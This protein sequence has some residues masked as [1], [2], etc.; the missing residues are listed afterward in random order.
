MTKL[1]KEAQIKLLRKMWIT[2]TQYKVLLALCFL[3]S[4]PALLFAYI[5]ESAI[6]VV[7]AIVLMGLGISLLFTSPHIQN[8]IGG[9]YTT[10]KKEAQVDMY[11]NSSLDKNSYCATIYTPKTTWE[12]EFAPL[13]W[14]PNIK[15]KEYEAHYIS[16]V[17]WPVLL[18][19]EDG[20]L[21]PHL[22]PKKV[23]DERLDFKKSRPTNSQELAQLEKQKRKELE[24][25]SKYTMSPTLSAHKKAKMPAPD[26]KVYT[27][28]K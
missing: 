7:L 21:Y 1:N 9:T 3:V 22:N 19:C 10:H 16:G 15:N 4:P 12:M 24:K 28:K 23:L 20:I 25:Q 27:A 17:D 11:L 8:A 2:P 5:T 6:V 14:S 26:P 18:S 13:N